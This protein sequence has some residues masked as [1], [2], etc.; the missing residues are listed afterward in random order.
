MLVAAGAVL[1]SGGRVIETADD[2]GGTVRQVAGRT[3]CDRPGENV[4]VSELETEA[5]PGRRCGAGI[6][7]ERQMAADA[8]HPGEMAGA[9]LPSVLWEI[10]GRSFAWQDW[11]TTVGDG[12][13]WWTAPAQVPPDF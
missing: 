10:V 12:V 6:E 13:C 1:V 11:Q 3:E 4:S 7:P 5:G 8:I 9:T 2:P